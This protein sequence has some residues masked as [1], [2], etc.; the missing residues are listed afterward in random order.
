M[1]AVV[2]DMRLLAVKRGKW[3]RER[4]AKGTREKAASFVTAVNAEM[5]ELDRGI[6]YYLLTAES[7]NDMVGMNA[8]NC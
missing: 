7:G 1:V 4:R 3:R 6:V 2:A 8:V 5:Y